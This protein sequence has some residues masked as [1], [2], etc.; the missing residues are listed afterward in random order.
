LREFDE[1]KRQREE[2]AEAKTAKN[3]AKRQKKKERAK[4]VKPAEGGEK[5]TAGAS[6]EQSLKKRRVVNGKEL[7]FRKPGE[8]SDEESDEEG[9]GP[10]PGSATA[11]QE[12]A[13]PPGV[14]VAETPT[15]VIHED[16]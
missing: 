8:E 3:R 5:K 7:V 9:P 11:A 6:E 13:S 10:Q 4:G 15:I 16:S 2:E 12:S 14:P 1:R